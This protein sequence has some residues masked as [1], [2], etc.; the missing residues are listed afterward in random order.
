MASFTGPLLGL[1]F[2][3]L[4]FFSNDFTSWLSCWHV[5]SFFF[6]GVIL[7]RPQ[8][9]HHRLSRPSCLGLRRSPPPGNAV[10]IIWRLF[11]CFHRLFWLMRRNVLFGL[12]GG[13]SGQYL[14]L[15]KSYNITKSKNDLKRRELH[16]I[17]NKKNS[18]NHFHV[19][20]PNHI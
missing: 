12:R 16:I 13:F 9:H 10:F 15:I 6:C 20:K 7:L 2:S 11:S 3:S 5:F 17:K 4:G 19:Q 1:F 14:T 18:K 8:R